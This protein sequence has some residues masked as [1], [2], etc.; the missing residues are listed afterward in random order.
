MRMPT[1]KKLSSIFRESVHQQESFKVNILI[2]TC[3]VVFSRSVTARGFS[4]VAMSGTPSELTAQP[5][6]RS[7]VGQD[8]LQSMSLD[9]D[10]PYISIMV[11]HV[12]QIC[13][14]GYFYKVQISTSYPPMILK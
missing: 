1:N 6:K 2:R 11:K 3:F 10:K 13:S 8:L 14:H 9:L 12:A 7:L 5:E 4:T